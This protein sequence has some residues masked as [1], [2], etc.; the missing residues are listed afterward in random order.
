MPGIS[1][2]ECLRELRK[3]DPD[4][5]VILSTGYLDLKEE[6][7]FRAMGISEIIQKPCD[8]DDFA[9]KIAEALESGDW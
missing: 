6:E 1:G 5:P 4:I 3:I 7:E 9:K 8:L 2:V